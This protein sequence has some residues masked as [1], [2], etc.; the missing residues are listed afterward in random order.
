MTSSQVKAW[1]ESTGKT[2]AV[3]VAWNAE[4]GQFQVSPCRVNDIANRL[5]TRRADGRC[6]FLYEI[7]DGAAAPLSRVACFDCI[8][9]PAD[10]RRTARYILVS[11]TPDW[12]V[13][14]GP[15]EGDTAYFTGE[16]L[17]RIACAILNSKR[18]GRAG[19]LYQQ[20]KAQELVCETLAAL[21]EGALIPVAA[22]DDFSAEDCHRLVQARAYIADNYSEKLTLNGISRAC[23]INKLKLTRGFREM[24]GCSVGDVL[25]EVRLTQAADQ[26]RLTARPVSLIGYECG[27]L[28]CASFS[29]AFTK[30][31]GLAPSRYR[32]KGR[33]DAGCP[34]AA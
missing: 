18:P 2:E 31:F 34:L 24:F 14:S 26:L 33:A 17:L 20:A 22:C 16:S 3:C 15:G 19:Y 25:A 30:R 5:A 32:N 7:Q 1:A 28:N 23:G 9:V 10:A 8:S 12:F 27:Y 11:L 21:E 13:V 4:H 6:L 29:R